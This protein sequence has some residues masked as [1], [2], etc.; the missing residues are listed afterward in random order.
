[1]DKEAIIQELYETT[2]HIYED[3]GELDEADFGAAIE[4]WRTQSI[5]DLQYQLEAL[6]S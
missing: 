3:A 5:E 6:K 1:M 4:Y 2:W